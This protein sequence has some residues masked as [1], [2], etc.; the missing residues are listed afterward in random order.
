MSTSNLCSG[1][2]PLLLPHFAWPFISETEASLGICGFLAAFNLS[3][4]TSSRPGLSTQASY[5]TGFDYAI[6]LSYTSTGSFAILT[7]PLL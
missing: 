1:S 7:L 3:R 4:N 5:L 2:V 6:R